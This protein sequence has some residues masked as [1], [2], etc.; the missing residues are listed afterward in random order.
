MLLVLQPLVVPANRR[1]HRRHVFHGLELAAVLWDPD[2][3]LLALK[4]DGH[5]WLIYLMLAMG[6]TFS[7]FAGDA[8]SLPHLLEGCLEL[9]QSFLMGEGLNLEATLGY[10]G[11]AMCLEEVLDQV[12]VARKLARGV[13]EMTPKEAIAI[14]E[15]NSCLA[16]SPCL[17]QV[18]IVKIKMSPNLFTALT[19]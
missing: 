11:W 14:S 7:Y 4:A 9:L 19:L 8:S 6:V 18:P 15:H 2:R 1:H 12:P 3:V 13:M 10:L 17:F 16:L 5:R